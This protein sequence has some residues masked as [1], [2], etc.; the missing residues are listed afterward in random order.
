MANEKS[1]ERTERELLIRIDERQQAMF[2]DLKSLKHDIKSDY[3][4][5]AEFEPVRRG[6]YGAL[7][8]FV[9]TVVTFLIT[10]FTGK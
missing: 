10:Y 6:A 1:N 9:G 8:L 4:T 7:T 3:V 5:K 2:D